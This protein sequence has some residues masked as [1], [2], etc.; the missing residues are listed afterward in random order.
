MASQLN[1][2]SVIRTFN[3]T[4]DF[5]TARALDSLTIAIPVACTHIKEILLMGG[6]RRGWLSQILLVGV[7][8][9]VL[10]LQSGPAWVQNAIILLAWAWLPYFLAATAVAD[11]FAGERERH[12]LE[13][14]LASRLSD[15][16][17]LF[18]KTIA[19]MAFACGLTWIALV[20]GL[21]TVNLASA[22]PGLLLY[23]FPQVV[24]LL[25]FTVL[26][27]GLAATIGVLI[28]LRAA[29]VRQA[30]QT[31]SVLICAFILPVIAIQFLPAEMQERLSQAL[32]GI[33]SWQIV[34]A[35]T[36]LLAALNLVFLAAA[37]ARF[38]RARLILE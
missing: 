6:G 13:T 21:V 17:I 5:E 18:G 11:T 7:F 32:A 16:A 8:G 2:E 29:S 28:S 35:G 31:I 36:A 12:T 24:G 26:G 30:A 14:L 34:R 38:Q 19:V 15:R 25:L 20:V 23:A 4:R 10:P 3:L 1:S 33:T 9:V 22:E 37:L 27:S